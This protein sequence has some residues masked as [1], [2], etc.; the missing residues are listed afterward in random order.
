M[1]SHRTKQTDDE[2]CRRAVAD[3]APSGVLRVALNLSNPNLVKHAPPSFLSGLAVDLAKELARRITFPLE[4]ICFPRAGRVVEAV[5]A[6]VWDVSS[7]R[8][9]RSARTNFCSPAPTLRSQAR[10][11]FK[12]IPAAEAMM[13]WI[14]KGIR[15]VVGKGSASDL[16][17]RNAM[18]RARLVRVPTT[19]EV[20]PSMLSGGDEVAAGV[21]QQLQEQLLNLPGLRVL[22]VGS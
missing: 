20:L 18:Q 6:N 14:G 22:E 8:S 7:W 19:A 13:T 15:I 16:F 9:I 21:R 3:L 1:P 4:L 5:D 17:L 2:R 11:W 12:R 10:S